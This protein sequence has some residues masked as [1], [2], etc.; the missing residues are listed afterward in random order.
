MP[1]SAD[2]LAVLACPSPDHAPLRLVSG[3]ESEELECT[4][5]AS[6]FPVRDDIPVLLPDD[7]VLG[8]NGLGVAANAVADEPAN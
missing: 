6:R 1:L 5:C 7:A 8:P 4:V 2:L 3:G